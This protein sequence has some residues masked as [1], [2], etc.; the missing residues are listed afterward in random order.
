M[1]KYSS[2]LLETKTKKEEFVDKMLAEFDLWFEKNKNNKLELSLSEIE[3]AMSTH[4]AQ[5]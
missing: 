5:Q 3:K 1:S 2:T 4:F